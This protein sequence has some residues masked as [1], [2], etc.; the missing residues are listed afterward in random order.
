MSKKIIEEET[1][2]QL[3]VENT[4]RGARFKIIL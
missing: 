2:A 4:L 3:S 1:N